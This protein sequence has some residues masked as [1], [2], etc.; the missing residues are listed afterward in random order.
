MMNRL[1]RAQE[2]A[3]DRDNRRAFR[4]VAAIV[5]ILVLGV[6]TVNAF[7]L[8]GAPPATDNSPAAEEI[9]PAA[10]PAQNR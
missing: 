1:A 3:N 6:L 10:P 9:A 5:V 4:W 7:W 2:R 8:K